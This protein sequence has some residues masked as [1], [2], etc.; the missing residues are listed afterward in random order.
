[1]P[2]FTVDIADD[3][4]FAPFNPANSGDDPSRMNI[5]AIHIPRRH[6]AEFQKRRTGIEKLAHPLTREKF[7]AGEMLVAR[8]LPTALLDGCHFFLQILD[9]ARHM[10]RIG[11]EFVTP[12]IEAAFQ[13]SHLGHFPFQH[14]KIDC[15]AK[16]AL[17][18]TDLPLRKKQ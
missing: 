2:P 6:L 12:G 9:E 5:P 17:C 1:M 15:L 7:S 10:R 16:V 3:D 4:T 18:V 13:Y 8:T 11:L 14:A